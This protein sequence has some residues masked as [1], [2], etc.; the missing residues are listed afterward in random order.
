MAYRPNMIEPPFDKR[1]A[2]PL[3]H[4][5]RHVVKRLA[6]IAVLVGAIVVPLPARAQD[7][8]PLASLLTAANND[9][10]VDLYGQLR[11]EP[12]NVVFAPYSLSIAISMIYLGAR[13]KTASE[14]ADLLHLSLLAQREVGGDLRSTLLAADKSH[15]VS[16][17][18]ATDT[19]TM[20][21]ANAMWGSV[22][23][24]FNPTF[25]SAIKSGLDAALRRVNF[26]PP[27]SASAQINGWVAAQTHNR[28]TE[29]VSP[30]SLS[31]DTQMILTNAIYFKANWM[32]PFSKAETEMAKFYPPGDHV[33]L[34][35]RMNDTTT[36]PFLHR[37]GMKL[38]SLPYGDRD[39][40][41]VIILPDLRDGLSAIESHL[42]AS[43]LSAWLHDSADTELDLSLPKFQSGSALDMKALLMALGMRDAFDPDQADL[44][45]IA[46]SPT[47]SLYI[48]TIIHQAVLTVDEAGTEA[49]AASAAMAPTGTAPP[50]PGA[51]PLPPIPFV[52]DHPFLYLVRAEESGDILFMGRVDDPNQP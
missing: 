14:I 2:D 4:E 11:L 1:I 12:G 26:A 10:A 9:F 41:L 33:I 37:D 21:T 45:D 30:N 23:Y 39:A 27:E 50:G 35:E 18:V 36:Y 40:S 16:S 25:V 29:L 15:G 31:A 8:P 51:K 7:V 44:R 17:G 43:R 24:A 13:G 22:S 52:V 34:A 48:S 28:I 20:S 5:E 49:S 19:F 46:E 3:V 42:T 38:V 47:H 6:K 32:F